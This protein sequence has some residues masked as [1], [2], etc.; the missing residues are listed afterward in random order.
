M[1]KIMGFPFQLNLQFK[2]ISDLIL[3]LICL[4]LAEKNNPPKISGL[5][6]F[7]FIRTA[8]RLWRLILKLFRS[9]KSFRSAAGSLVAVVLRPFF[10]FSIPKCC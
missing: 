7:F 9:Q 3:I 10:R 1:P 4:A 8:D 5:S 6:C 2:K